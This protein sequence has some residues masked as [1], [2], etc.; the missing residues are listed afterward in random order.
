MGA[1][2][3]AARSALPPRLADTS[4]G[5][6]ASVR[7]RDGVFAV[8]S[9]V[10]GGGRLPGWRAHSQ[11]GA[12][13]VMVS[14]HT[15]TAWPQGIVVQSQ[16]APREAQLV[17]AVPPSAPASD[18][19]SASAAPAS[20]ELRACQAS[21]HARGI[22]AQAGFRTQACPRNHAAPHTCVPSAPNQ[23]AFVASILAAAQDS[24][25]RV[26]R[27]MRFSLLMASRRSSSVPFP[28]EIRAAHS[29]HD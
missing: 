27:Q 20:R 19:A 17:Q 5:C 25:R 2:G 14:P 6:W 21:R 29:S 15:V 11:F 22:G 13:L 4:E 1:R 10:P 26:N 28:D 24:R 16:V 18:G 8:R 12:Q 9:Q 23:C 3:L 7:P